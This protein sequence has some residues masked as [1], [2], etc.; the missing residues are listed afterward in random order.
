MTMPRV[1]TEIDGGFNNDDGMPRRIERFRSDSSSLGRVWVSRSWS[2]SGSGSSVVSRYILRRNS[3]RFGDGLGQTLLLSFARV[4]DKC[5]G[6][7]EWCTWTQMQEQH[8]LRRRR[9]QMQVKWFQYSTPKSMDED[10]AE[11]ADSDHPKRLWLWS[12]TGEFLWQ[13]YV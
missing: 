12:S 7:E 13:G 8:E 10:V 6:I 11:E 1:Y 3:N 2:L 5:L 9:G 4:A